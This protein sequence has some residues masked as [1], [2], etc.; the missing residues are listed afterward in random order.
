LNGGITWQTQQTL[1]VGDPD[2]FVTVFDAIKG[3]IHVMIQNHAADVLHTISSDNGVTWSTPSLITISH[4]KYKTV[5]PGVAHGLQLTGRS[6]T[7]GRLILPFICRDA[8]SSIPSSSFTMACPGCYTCMVYSDDYGITWHIGGVSPHVG[9]REAC[10]IQ[11]DDHT[12]STP[13]S[14]SSSPND[15]DI[16][17]SE[18]ISSVVY[19]N[20]RNMGASP[21]HRQHIISHDSGLT[22]DV[23]GI[24]TLPDVVA[25]NWTGVVAGCARASTPNRPLLFTAPSAIKAR[26]DLALWQSNDNGV[27]W[28]NTPRVL[29]AGPAGYS[30]IIPLNSTHMALLV[31]NGSHEFAQKIT[32]L[33]FPLVP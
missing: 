3:V 6:S 8:T 19:A 27:T 10:I 5:I 18:T 21:G 20:E 22:F 15:N 12:I 11:L 9:S 13:F 1:F 7:A 31:E 30:D 33:P 4:P 28:S 29:V 26:A 17:I 2:F 16:N 24:D 23:S 14:I 25:T 32:F